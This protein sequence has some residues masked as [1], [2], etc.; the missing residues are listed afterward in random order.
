MKFTDE[1]LVSF[2][3]ADDQ[4]SEGRSRGWVSDFVHFLERRFTQLFNREIKIS[5][6]PDCS[7]SYQAGADK[8]VIT[9]ISNNFLSSSSCIKFLQDLHDANDGSATAG[10]KSF[11]IQMEAV[12]AKSI[13]KFPS[14]GNAYEFF[15]SD[16]AGVD[17]LLITGG[18]GQLNY[19]LALEN[20]AFDIYSTTVVSDN[21]NV[22]RLEGTL[23]NGEK[24]FLGF[25]GK[26]TKPQRNR[27]KWEL[28]HFGFRVVPL[29]QMSPNEQVARG[30]SK[31]ML[32]GALLSVHLVGEEF[33]PKLGSGNTFTPEMHNAVAAEYC[34][35]HN[36]QRL[37]WIP[38]S[39]DISDEKEH[40]NLSR[41]RDDAD[42]IRGAEIFQIPIEE[43]TRV[44]L[45]KIEEVRAGSNGSM[46]GDTSNSGKN[47][48]LIHQFKDNDEAGALRKQLEDQGLQVL[49]LEGNGSSLETKRRH[50]QH[51]VECD[52]AMIYYA[53]A[54]PIWL[55]MK[56]N[57]LRR[58][59]GM[60]RSGP[61][62]LKAV[63]LTNN[64][65]LPQWQGMDQE[66]TILRMEGAGDPAAMRDFISQMKGT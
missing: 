19:F 15:Q 23:G 65:D 9:V 66:F 8:I 46:S 17:Q 25:A 6:N 33:D 50:A 3:A 39:L 7:T 61:I 64:T 52:A 13:K 49:M 26:D 53:D 43:F 41:L 51:L 37:I 24:I 31:E 62:S 47:L 32:E 58:S 27:I 4:Q 11:F 42:A 38:P 16:D 34:K 12:E 55:E 20:L 14:I 44:V 2:A 10:L 36:L 18:E 28:E 57:D 35:T 30:L 63:Y 5:L 40:E 56:V 48:Y 54:N 1:I 45:T 29:Q 21:E 59:A 22:K 60:G